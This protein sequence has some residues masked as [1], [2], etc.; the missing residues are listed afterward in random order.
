MAPK[1]EIRGLLFALGLVLGGASFCSAHGLTMSTAS[2]MIRNKTH[3]IVRLQ[4]DPVLLLHQ[5]TSGKNPPPPLPLLA[6]MPDE[7]FE[8]Q[9]HAIQSIFTQKLSL[10]F[11]GK[12]V[13]SVRL[14]F[15][16]VPQFRKQIR[17]RFMHEVI[18]AQSK[19]K[20]EPHNDRQYYQTIEADGFLP[21]SPTKGALE[22]HFP[23]ELGQILVTFSQPQSQ[24]LT[25]D[26]TGVLYRHFVDINSP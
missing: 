2:V 10:R 22:I 15:P 8:K 25:P 7:L 18:Q 9:Y 23:R 26:D 24:T 3:V 13:H 16:T 17:A 5:I 12:P 21:D 20:Q 6:N 1:T 4:Y 11:A 14:R 19:G